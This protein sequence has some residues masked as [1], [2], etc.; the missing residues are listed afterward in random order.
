MEIRGRVALVT[1][2][3]RRVGKA[4]ALALG[5][6]GATVAVHYNMSRGGAEDTVRTIGSAGG[7]ARAIGA[8]LAIDRSLASLVPDVVREF[9]SLDILVNSASIF[10]DIRLFDTTEAEWDE[11]FRVNVRAPFVLSREMARA[12][13]GRPGKIVNLNDWK[14]ARPK[15]FAYGVSKAALSGLTRSLA[16]ALAPSIQVNEVALGAIL[17]PPGAEAAYQ[18]VLASRAPAKRMGTPE[19]VADAVLWLI[20]ND[21]VTGETVRVDGGQHLGRA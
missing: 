14:N 19:E 12:L 7:R 2:A 18:K 3:G 11:N 6:A 16:L 13:N 5:Q 8:D 21:Y 10:R 4:V 1:G 20:G 17:L 15:R 9:G